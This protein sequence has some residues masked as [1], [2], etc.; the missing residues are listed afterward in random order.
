LAQSVNMK[1]HSQQQQVI[2][3]TIVAYAQASQAAA[4]IKSSEKAVQAAEQHWLDAKALRVRGM[5]LDSD[6]MD[7]HVYLLRS[8][9]ARSEADYVYANSLGFLRLVM[10]MD[11]AQVILNLNEPTLTAVDGS[12]EYLQEKSLNQRSDLIAMQ[13]ELEAATSA[14]K[15]A[16]ASDLPRVDLVAGQE[17]NSETIGLKNRNSMIGLTMTMN[18]FNGGSDQARLRSVESQYASLSFQLNDKKQQIKHEIAQAWRH[19][20]IA[21]L[22]FKSEQEALQQTQESLRIK[23]L[24]YKQGLEKTADLLSAQVKMDASTV[25]HIQAKYDVMVA[26]AALMLAA[27]MLDEGVIQ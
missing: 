15:V 22:R 13:H 1:L 6:V 14:R 21:E 25:V 3:Q 26:K 24:R 20:N 23:L 17:W 8:Q 12:I 9:V 19:L 5:V 4:Q 27:G 11:M 18:I 10:G 2:Y 7:A 16:Y